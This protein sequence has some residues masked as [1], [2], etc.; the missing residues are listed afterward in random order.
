VSPLKIVFMG[1]PGFAVP[2]LK[3]LHAHHPI[4]GVYTQPPRPAG[5]GYHLQLSDVHQ[6]A[7]ALNLPVHTPLTLK[8][9][10]A[11]ETLKALAPD[12][13]IVV[14]YGLILPKAVLDI[15]KYGCLNVHGSLLPRWRGAAPIQRAIMAGDAN[16]GVTIMQM[17]VGM[18]TGPM[19]AHKTVPITG[20]S[21]TNSLLDELSVLGAQALLECLPPYVAGTLTPTLQPAEGVAM[22]P[23]I[24]KAEMQGDWEDAGILERKI[25]ALGSIWFAYQ[26]ERIKIL[27]AKAVAKPHAYPA[28]YVIDN[29]LAIACHGGVLH[30]TMVQKAGG[31][32]QSVEDFLHGHPISAGT[33]LKP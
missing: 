26:G 13:I 24:G 25:R 30:P 14:A 27:K 31:K 10:Q 19:L 21:T 20:T 22:A 23:K 5:R 3:V 18:D 9:P 28:G 4:M 15:P 32:A 2:T 1:T 11:Q 16:T 6:V 12:I 33:I 17:D 8:D 29:H 7:D